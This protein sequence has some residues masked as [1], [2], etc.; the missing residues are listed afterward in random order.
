[1]S[2]PTTSAPSEE[3]GTN[4][5][6]AEALESIRARPGRDPETGQFLPGNIEAG[7]SLSR[8]EALWSALAPAKAAL[9]GKL[10]ADLALEQGGA[11]AT[12]EGLVD[13]YAEARLLRSSLFAR[14]ADEGG[15]VTTKGKTRALFAAWLSA[16]DRETKLATVLGLE[17]RQRPVD[18]LERVHR[19]VVEARDRARAEGTSE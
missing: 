12:L 13:A 8:S 15:P 7:R 5:R 14:M 17:R 3:L 4:G 1:M 2:A 6:V 18:P 11:A 16:V 19:A 9:V 10:R